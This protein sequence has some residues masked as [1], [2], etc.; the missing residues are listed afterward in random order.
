M[1]ARSVSIMPKTTE[2]HLAVEVAD[3]AQEAV[4]HMVVEEV[5]VE[6][7]ILVVDSLEVADLHSKDSNSK[8]NSNNSIHRT[9]ALVVSKVGRILDRRASNRIG[10]N[11]C[12]IE[13][14]IVDG[15]HCHQPY[16]DTLCCG[17]H[18]FSVALWWHSR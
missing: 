1:A 4:Q 11:I 9:V 12:A 14:I 18:I 3:T 7:S 13:K 6:A 17:W 10:S 8:I 15:V 2:A 16:T 5:A